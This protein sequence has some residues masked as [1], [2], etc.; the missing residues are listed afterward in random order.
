M[1]VVG[2]VCTTNVT[3]VRGVW[4]LENGG[5]FLWGLCVGERGGSPTGPCGVSHT[6]GPTA[7]EHME[8]VKIVEGYSGQIREF[9]AR[10][11]G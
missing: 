11:N 8:I 5:Y 9:F 4:G 7:D 6:R 10:F 2:A 3:V 1:A